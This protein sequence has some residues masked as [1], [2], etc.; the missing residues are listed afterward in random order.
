VPFWPGL[1]CSRTREV[2]DSRERRGGEARAAGPAG[3]DSWT[4]DTDPHRRPSDRTAYESGNSL[5]TL[6]MPR[7]ALLSANRVDDGPRSRNVP[8][9]CRIAGPDPHFPA[10]GTMVLRQPA[11]FFGA[12]QR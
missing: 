1:R 12:H 3:F 4:A 10:V 6:V 9:P 2:E 11:H 5:G 8:I 7:L